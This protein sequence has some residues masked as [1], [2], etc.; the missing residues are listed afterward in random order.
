[1]VGSGGKADAASAALSRAVGS[2][3]KAGAASASS[4][5]A[6]A[7]GSEKSEAPEE[8]W[9]TYLCRGLLDQLARLGRGLKACIAALWQCCQHVFYPL[10]ELFFEFL[11]AWDACMHPFKK[12]RPVSDVSGFRYDAVANSSAQL[13]RASH[14]YA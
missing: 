1:M 9:A 8:T 3:G 7:A 13:K 5:D 14:G 6:E 4:R 10:K 2:G 12:K 11:D